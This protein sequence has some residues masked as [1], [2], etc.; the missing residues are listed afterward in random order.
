[1]TDIKKYRVV[2]N[3]EEEWTFLFQKGMDIVAITITGQ[4]E[5]H[6]IV[7]IQSPDDMI[8][9]SKWELIH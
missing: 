3:I 9:G 6:V 4:D 7:E 1:M 5:N 8:E 2:V